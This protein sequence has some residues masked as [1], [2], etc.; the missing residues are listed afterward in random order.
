MKNNTG[1][2]IEKEKQEGIGLKTKYIG[3]NIIYFDTLESTN[4][5]GK[6]LL[7]TDFSFGTCIVADRQTSGKGRLNRQWFSG[8]GQNVCFSILLKPNIFIKQIGIVTLGFA[9]AVGDA[10]YDLYGVRTSYKWPNDIV[11][12]G[13]KLCGIL[14]EG[15]FDTKMVGAVVGIGINIKKE[16]PDDLKPIGISLEEIVGNGTEFDRNK[17]IKLILIKADKI[18]ESI[19]NG[20]MTLVIEKWKENNCVIGKEIIAGN[21]TG[22][23]IDIDEDGGL[24]IK[25]KDGEIEKVISGEVSIRGK[26]SYI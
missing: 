19:E 6:E 11:Y 17:L 4:E 24:L 8:N 15:V 20:D 22:K 2:I 26:N 23:V 10:I 12:Q 16:L 3:N 14:F 18:V 7:K 1:K 13:R 21:I 5:Y 25:T 9:V